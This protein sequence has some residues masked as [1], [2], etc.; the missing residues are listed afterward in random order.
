[1]Y[2]ALI[3]N[4]T[5]G[6]SCTNSTRPSSV[7]EQEPSTKPNHALGQGEDACH[8]AEVRVAK[9]TVRILIVR[10]VQLR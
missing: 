4:R 7:L 1:M 8:A 2:K 3:A 6:A 5:T 10:R 9:R